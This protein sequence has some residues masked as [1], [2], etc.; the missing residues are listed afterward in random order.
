M[1]SIGFYPRYIEQRLKD[2]LED[3]PVVLIYGPRQCGKTTLAQTVCAPGNSSWNNDSTERKYRTA[4]P[5][6]DKFGEYTYISF[7]NKGPR[8]FA[9]NDPVGFA[10][11]LPQRVILDEVQKVPELFEALKIEVD[12]NRVPGRFLLTGSANVLQVPGL[13]DSL[14]GRM[15]MIRLHPLAQC[16]MENQPP[17]GFLDTLFENGFKVCQTRRLGGELGERISAGGYPAALALPPGQ[18]RF[19][20]YDSYIMT[21]LLKDVSGFARIS[22]LETLPQLLTIAATR[23][24]GLFNVSDI[25]SSFELSRHT[26][27]NYIKL[28]EMAFLLERIPPWY[29]NLNLRLVKTPKLHM[30]DTGLA[31]ALLGIDAD[32]LMQNRP[33]LGQLLETFVLQEMRR[34]ASWHKARLSFYHY[35]DRKGTEVDIV[36]ERGALAVAGIEIKASGTVTKADFRGLNKLEK[37][38]G[39]RFVCGAV[40]YDGNTCLRYG[41]RMWAIPL[42]MLWENPQA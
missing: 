36:I 35:R 25:S 41:D 21:Q 28:L 40:L 23:T 13:S 42:R 17:P 29:R 8:E 27:K 14:A 5:A 18:R 6:D 11:A 16:E 39:R 9:K 2:A 32:G 15:L 37:T 1:P 22:T 12:R 3:S 26:V 24:A 7:D 31:C 4:S 33:L 30:C 19:D 10:S 38:V 20:W 34:Q